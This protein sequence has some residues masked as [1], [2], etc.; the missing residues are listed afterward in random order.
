MTPAVAI[1]SRQVGD[2]HP[3]FVIAEGGVNH[4]GDLAIA[5]AIIDAAAASGADAVKFQ[6]FS[7]DRL[8][9]ATAPKAGYQNVTTN[10]SETQ[11][12]MLKRLELSADA[13]RQLLE[14]ARARDIEFLSSSFDAGSADLLDELGLSVFKLG[15]GE[16]TDIPLL[17]HVARKG[18]PM[19]LSTGMSWLEEVGRAVEAIRAVGPV[20]IALLHCVSNY[21]AATTDC[22]L[23]AMDAMR[24]AFDVPVG[25]SDHT[26][27]L[28]AAV[29][30]VARGACIVEKHLTLDRGLPGPDHLASCDPEEFAALVRAI[31]ETEA[32]LGDGVKRPVEAE[33]P[34]RDVARKSV[35]ALVDI[36]KGQPLT[37]EM[38]GVRRPGTGI[39][40]ADLDRLVGRT[41]S[42]D[43]RA[44]SLL[45][46]ETLA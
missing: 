9:T 19:L 32:S 23:R 10:P 16:L 14:H 42:G 24:A 29:A 5:R 8:V 30:A 21:P 44:G 40:P 31:R 17:R 12:A 2:G 6:T 26:R 28:L 18:R 36:P 15:S 4:N 45:D 35:V 33:L 34:T 38:L 11:H 37:R 46:W 1:G 13:H 25:Y 7:A 43:V 27:G 20:P 41:P 39:A 22:N 3:V